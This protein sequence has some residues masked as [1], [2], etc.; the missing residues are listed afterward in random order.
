M[1]QKIDFSSIEGFDTL[2]ENI[3]T[4][5]E[6]MVIDIPEPDY[7]GYVKKDLLDKKLSELA[8]V[9]KQLRAKSSEAELAEIEKQEQFKKLNEELAALKKEKNIS[10]YK[11]KLIAQGYDE[12]LALDTAT[13]MESGEF[14]KVF[15]NQKSFLENQK[16]QWETTNIQKQPTLTSGKTLTSGDVKTVA[17]NALRRSFGL[18]EQ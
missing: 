14:D 13:A 1:Q 12:K 17:D 15:D 10:T 4:Q 5:L 8:S 16:K 11:A 9:N 7:K 2:D 3:K 18:P 6:N